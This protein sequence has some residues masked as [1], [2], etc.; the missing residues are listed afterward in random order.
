M[1]KAP[2]RLYVIHMDGCPTCEAVVPVVRAW[3]KERLSLRY[4]EFDIT[5]DEWKAQAWQ[6]TQMPTLILMRP[7][8]QLF[9][10]MGPWRLETLADDVTD[11]A[12]RVTRG[13]REVG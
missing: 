2:Y 9:Y 6:P 13:A 8:K 10:K 1:R 3:A 5:R 12:R 11:W 4:V 7:D